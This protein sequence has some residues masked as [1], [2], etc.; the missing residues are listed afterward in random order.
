M[1][2][3]WASTSIQSLIGESDSN[4]DFG[5]EILADANENNITNGAPR[6]RHSTSD[7]IPGREQGPRTRSLKTPANSQI[8]P[9]DSSKLGFLSNKSTIVGE[10][11]KKVRL[12]TPRRSSQSE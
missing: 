6:Y 10:V 3:R 8:L 12:S 5:V 11:L 9:S 1:L 2:K 4:M 7:V